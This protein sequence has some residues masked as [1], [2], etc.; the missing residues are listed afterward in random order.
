MFVDDAVTLGTLYLYNG[1]PK[2]AHRAG[3]KRNLPSDEIT[4]TKKVRKL[5]SSETVATI[6]QGSKTSDNCSNPSLNFPYQTC[7]FVAHL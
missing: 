4:I 5:P 1:Q 6:L 3:K 2:N 7:V